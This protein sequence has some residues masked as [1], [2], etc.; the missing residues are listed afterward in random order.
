MAEA[1]RS[2]SWSTFLLAGR[3]GLSA[4]A[5]I[6]ISQMRWRLRERLQVRDGIP[7]PCNTSARG[8]GI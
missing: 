2:T 4:G 3:G 5:L 8:R 7:A 6:A 1:S